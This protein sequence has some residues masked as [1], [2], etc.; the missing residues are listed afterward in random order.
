MMGLYWDPRVAESFSYRVVK[1]R[2]VTWERASARNNNSPA[3]LVSNMGPSIARTGLCL[4]G[5]TSTKLNLTEEELDPEESR[6]R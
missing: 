5:A 1:R 3:I 4:V 2:H 6:S